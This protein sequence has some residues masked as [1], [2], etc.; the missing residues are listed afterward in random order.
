MSVC[1]DFKY[2]IKAT[3]EQDYNLIKSTFKN[4]DFEDM[5]DMPQ[6]MKEMITECEYND[7]SFE[8]KFEVI[9]FAHPSSLEFHLEILKAIVR[10]NQ[11]ISFISTARD[12]CTDGENCERRLKYKCTNGKL[13]LL[14]YAP[15]QLFIDEFYETSGCIFEGIDYYEY[16]LGLLELEEPWCEWFSEVYPSSYKGG[17]YFIDDEDE[18]F[19]DIDTMKESLISAY[20]QVL[21]KKSDVQVYAIRFT[22]DGERTGFH[23]T[24]DGETIQETELEIDEKVYN[25]EIIDVFEIKKIDSA[26]DDEEYEDEDY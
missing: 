13:E 1:I 12:S 3:T 23:Y 9:D 18:P 16:A 21:E 24:F 6:Y 2:T 25:S 20:K 10:K 11:L 26:Y 15:L 14:H 4:G 5:G 8:I 7:E 19:D 17:I 22:K